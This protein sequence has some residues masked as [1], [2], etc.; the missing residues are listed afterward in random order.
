MVCMARFLM[1][2]DATSWR[3]IV[4]LRIEQ[5]KVPGVFRIQLSSGPS[6]DDKPRGL[7]PRVTVKPHLLAMHS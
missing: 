3:V 1:N 5:T 6:L 2:D 7:Q 4:A